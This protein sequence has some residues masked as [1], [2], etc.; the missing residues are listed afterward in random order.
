[1]TKPQ[2]DIQPRRHPVTA[3]TRAQATPQRDAPTQANW[4]RRDSGVLDQ[5]LQSFTEMWLKGIPENV[6]PLNCAEHYPRVL[7]KIA[8]LWSLNERCMDYLNEL[9]ID[10]RGGRQGFSYGV[11]GE[12]RRLRTHRVALMSAAP[13]PEPPDANGHTDFMST[14]PMPPDS[15]PPRR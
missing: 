2:D 6:R 4:K 1:M 9:V 13:P 11:L 3:D 5:S 15:W 7:N 8:A 10:V 12:L 14:V